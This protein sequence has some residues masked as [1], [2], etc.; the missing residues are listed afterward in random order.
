MAESASSTVP[1]GDETRRMMQNSATRA[2][3]ASAV[4]IAGQRKAPVTPGWRLLGR[5]YDC[6]GGGHWGLPCVTGESPAALCPIKPCSQRLGTLGRDRLI[7]GLRK[8]AFELV[9]PEREG[10]SGAIASAFG[11]GSANV[12]LPC[13]A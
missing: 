5:F 11:C 10:L 6:V 9:R 3:T 1:N 4:P 7:G 12:S 13:R 2:S 8:G